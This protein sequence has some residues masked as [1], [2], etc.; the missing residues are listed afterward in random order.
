[1]E[2]FVVSARKYRPVAFD[3]VIGQDHITSTL[4][5][6]INNNKLA[7]AFLFCGPRGIGK[8]TCARILAKTI[9][10]E[11]LSDT[12]EA[13][14]EC[15]SCRT[16]NESTSLNIHELDAASNNSVDDIRNLIEQVRYAPQL[17]KYKIYI[18]DEVHMLSANAFNAFLK[19]LEE[20]PSYAIFILATTE[21][22]KII[23]TI[24]SRCQIFDFKRIQIANIVDHLKLIAKKEDHQVEDEALHLI[25]E[26]SDGALRDALTI[27][28][29]MVNFSNGN[30]T[31]RIVIDNLHIL[32]YDYYFRITD[33]I[34]TSDSSNALLIFD[35]ILN[36]GFD[37]HN[38][39]NGLSQ[40]LRNLLVIK[41]P[42]TLQLLEVSDSV[43]EKYKEQSLNCSKSLLLTTLN[44]ANQCDVGYKLS[45]SARLHV[46]LALLKMCHTNTAIDLAKQ[47]GTEVSLKKKSLTEP[48]THKLDTSKSESDQKNIQSDTTSESKPALQVDKPI[49]ITSDPIKIEQAK[50]IEVVEPVNPVMAPEP[51]VESQTNTTPSS[52]TTTILAEPKSSDNYS[53]NTVKIGSLEDIKKKIEQKKSNVQITEDTANLLKNAIDP[54]KFKELWL[55]YAEDLKANGKINLYTILTTK[56]P[57]VSEDFIIALDIENKVQLEQIESVRVDLVQHLREKLSNYSLDIKISVTENPEKKNLLYTSHD[58]YN[59]MVEKNPRI[60]E[61]KDRLDLEIEF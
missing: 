19:T 58:K 51:K 10:C 34:L 2:K 24:L 5:N 49:E 56:L 39:I 30:L 8:T 59:R 16:F 38:F 40:H 20:P 26:K 12:I 50:E 47:S 61:L 13:C 36:Q 28:D 31:Y 3:T 45:K 41:D 6:S 32:D 60:Q 57:S 11:N 22:H 46:E 53:V 52:V 55:K 42:Q 14:N 33:S 1:M 15:N 25:A 37:G 44:I 9:N 23:P 35:D 17:G 29:Q 21:K 7:Q 54:E 18:I 27:Y 43:K 48:T 4:K